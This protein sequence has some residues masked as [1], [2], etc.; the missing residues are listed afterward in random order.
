MADEEYSD[1][2]YVDNDV[3]VDGDVDDDEEME[4]GN[5]SDTNDASYTE[6]TIAAEVGGETSGTTGSNSATTT[7]T[8]T[9]TT[10]ATAGHS[11]RRGK[12]H[13][14]KSR[15]RSN[16]NLPSRKT[17]TPAAEENEVSPLNDEYD[18]PNDIKGDRK[19]S[20]LGVLKGGRK[21]RFKTFKVPNKGDRLYAIS[22]DVARLIGYRDSY[23]LFQKHTS[24]Y[25]YKVDEASKMKLIKDDLLPGTFKTRAA[26][27]ITARSAFKEFGAR[28]IVNGKM[29]MDDYYED[30]AREN[31]AIE[32]ALANPILNGDSHSFND[33]SLFERKEN[34]AALLSKNNIQ[35]TNESWIY[36]HA[37]KSRQ[38][39]SMLLYD[40]NELLKKRVQRDIYTNLNFVPSTTQPTKSKFIKFSND[41]DPSS[42]KVQIET[43]ISDFNVI[44]TGLFSV[45]PSVW[46]GCVDEETKNAILLQ[47]QRETTF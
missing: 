38:F 10:T 20:E 2:Q 5:D 34:M 44:K 37:L 31:G 41:G 22:T 29:V 24:L 7:T 3:D 23:F 9:T 33:H 14:S 25:R 6:S 30:K 18:T 8:T 27:L 32:G 11:N 4:D 21:F 15:S 13:A 19:I 43:T 40:R 35:G 26:Y 17:P 45:D 42:G 47:Q 36:D 1:D 12:H 46:E 16:S 39:D 28:L